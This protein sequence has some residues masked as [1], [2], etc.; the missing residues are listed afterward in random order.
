MRRHYLV[1]TALCLVSIAA[2]TAACSGRIASDQ[3]VQC[4]EGLKTAYGELEDAKVKGFSGTLA[5]SK[6]AS[7]LTAASVQKEF[8][9][10]PNCVDKVERAR[11]YI[12]E[13]QR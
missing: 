1:G 3:A 7:L 12:R 4:S 13:A 5:W 10:Y 6:A 11:L 2:L 8:E 9:K